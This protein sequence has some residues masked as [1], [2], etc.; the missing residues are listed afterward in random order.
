MNKVIKALEHM[1]DRG[2]NWFIDTTTGGW[3]L[4]L[5][6]A[7]SNSGSAVGF[8]QDDVIEFLKHYEEITN[9]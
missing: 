9:A 5:L 8:S 4:G 6:Y 2:G 1:A 7:R 3:Y